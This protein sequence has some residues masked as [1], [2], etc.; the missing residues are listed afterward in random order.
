MWWKWNEWFLITIPAPPWCQLEGETI[1]EQS[2]I[3]R[4]CRSMRQSFIKFHFLISGH[5]QHLSTRP[6]NGLKNKSIS[7]FPNPLTYI[8]SQRAPSK[9]DY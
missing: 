9:Q 7:W 2:H 4:L 8:R 3:D 5:K 1:A 6:Y